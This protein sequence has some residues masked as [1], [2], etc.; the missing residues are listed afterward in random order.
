MSDKK[1][2]LDQLI[3]KWL[4]DDR[5][6]WIQISKVD[7]NKRV[8]VRGVH[9]DGVEK[10]KWASLIPIALL[11]ST[12]EYYHFGRGD[13]LKNGWIKSSVVYLWDLGNGQ[14]GICDGNHRI[15]AVVSLVELGDL[16]KE[17]KILAYILKVHSTLKCV[18]LVLICKLLI[19][20][21]KL[22]KK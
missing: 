20:R 5:P 22:L 18:C 9:T 11:F 15:I 2:S 17:F 13:I 14:Y 10:L 1:E 4:I 21:P 6:Q 3:S 12:N 19:F 7:P 8:D 16:T